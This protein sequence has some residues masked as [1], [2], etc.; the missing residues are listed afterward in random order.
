MRKHSGFCEP[1][2][3]WLCLLVA[4]AIVSASHTEAAVPVSGSARTNGFQFLDL[5]RVAA[6]QGS[7][8]SK[9]FSLLQEGLQFHDGVPFMLGEKVA[10]TGLESSQ[11]GDIYPSEVNL[12]V[13]SKFKRLHLLHS[14][15]NYA[16]DG[17][18][19]AAIKIHYANGE[20]ESLRIGYGIHVRAW[21]RS[22]MEKKTVLADVNSRQLQVGMEPGDLQ[23]GLRYYHSA[24]ENPRPNEVVA[25]VEVQSFFSRATPVILAVSLE[26]ESSNLGPGRPQTSR[27]GFKDL[28]QFPDSVY[29]RY[30]IARAT[31]GAGGPPL[32]NAV[33]AL[34]ISDDSHAFFVGEAQADAQ[35]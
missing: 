14:T 30:L 18:P 17:T 8:A 10:V 35:G 34:A 33:A 20:Q 21:T 19:L 32:T 2:S 4:A 7:E 22:G 13:G 29:R 3:P 28:N 25:S 9:R 1:Q 23:R 11:A 16:K 6:P 31:A 5:S 26:G 12:G 15:L 24:L 27:K